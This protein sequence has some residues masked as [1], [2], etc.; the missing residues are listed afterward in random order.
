VL[1]SLTAIAQDRPAIKLQRKQGAAIIQGQNAILTNRI[2]Q[3][4]DTTIT[5]KLTR[6]KIDYFK[7]NN[8]EIANTATEFLGNYIH[9][10]SLDTS[11]KEVVSQRILED[12]GFE[13]T[14]SDGSKKILYRG[15]YTIISP[16]GKKMSASYMSVSPLI[17]PTPPA[18]ENLKKYLQNVSDEL[19]SILSGLL[20]NDDSSIANFKK[21]DA[22]LNIY[23]IINRR[24][25]FIDYCNKQR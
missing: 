11:Q 8:L 14:F 25:V 21:G 15:G 16:D 9:T 12:G 22:N 24:I 20:N 7:Q 19:L 5:I 1:G 17:P 2:S 3:F 10:V 18:D 6:K 4:V 13:Q 23:E